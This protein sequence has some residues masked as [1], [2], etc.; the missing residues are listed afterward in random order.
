M[1]LYQARTDTDLKRKIENDFQSENGFAF[2][3][4]EQSLAE[5][6]NKALIV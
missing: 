6:W 1:M 2:V 4:I 5:F 3:E